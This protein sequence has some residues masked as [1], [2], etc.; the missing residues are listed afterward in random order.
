MLR[1]PEMVLQD[2]AAKLISFPTV[3]G[4]ADAVNDLYE[5]VESELDLPELA[6]TYFEL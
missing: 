3:A 6:F 5:Y 4:A 2:I 1:M